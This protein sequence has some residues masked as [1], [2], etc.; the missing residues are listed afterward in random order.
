MAAEGA[1]IACA[2]DRMSLPTFKR[3]AV[4]CGWDAERDIKEFV[5]R[6]GEAENYFGEALGKGG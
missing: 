5:H 1:A 4:P 3:I 2:K 6:Y